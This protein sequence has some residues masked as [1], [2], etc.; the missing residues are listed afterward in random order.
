MPNNIAHF[1]VPADDVERARRF[2]ERVFGWRFEAWGP[3]DFYLIHTG[4]PADPGIHGSLSKRLHAG[5]GR[6]RTGFECTISVADLGPIRAAVVANGGKLVLDE[7]EI[8]GIGTLIRFE[9]T[10]GNVVC[11]MRYLEE[12]S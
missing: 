3:P 1:D 6:A 8:V 4:T 2:Y 12:T 10:E 5:A 11:A 7:H 9:D